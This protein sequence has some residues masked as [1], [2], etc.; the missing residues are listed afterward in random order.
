LIHV[1]LDNVTLDGVTD[2]VIVDVTCELIDTFFVELLASAVVVLSMNMNVVVRSV[3]FVA[4][5]VVLD[6]CVAFISHA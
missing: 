6:T 5:V 1:E 2:V 4:V 3:L